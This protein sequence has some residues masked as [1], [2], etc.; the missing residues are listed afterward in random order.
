M[1]FI[2]LLLQV[3]LEQVQAPMH[4]PLRLDSLFLDTWL[5]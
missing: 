4:G 1:K 5:T 3:T 2:T